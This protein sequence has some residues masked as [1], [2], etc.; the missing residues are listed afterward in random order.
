MYL[1]LNE[2]GS[3]SELGF[4]PKFNSSY[5]LYVNTRN[6]TSE[7]YDKESG[8]PIKLSYILI[9]MTI[10]LVCVII[11]FFY[12][13]LIDFFLNIK[14]KCRTI[15]FCKCKNF[16]IKSKI[17]P[18]FDD[19]QTICTDTDTCTICLSVNNQKSITLRCDHKFHEAC[20]KEWAYISYEKTNNA[21]CPL[22]RKNIFV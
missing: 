19:C 22:C 13:D 12:D 11:P 10:C 4:G 20:I 3:G 7:N 16:F 21:H 9:L 8:I 18:I 1:L 2:S 5:E 17:E 6:T 15:P 14:S